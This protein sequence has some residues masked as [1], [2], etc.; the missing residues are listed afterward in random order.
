MN[1]NTG[2]QYVTL[3]GLSFLMLTLTNVEVQAE[4]PQQGE[5]E[6]R[7]LMPMPQRGQPNAAQAM[8]EPS[9]PQRKRNSS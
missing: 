3:A 7:G 9:W 4:E 2:C 1:I 6:S 5:I 8:Q